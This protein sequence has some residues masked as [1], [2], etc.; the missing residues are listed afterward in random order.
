[1]DQVVKYFGST[2]DCKTFAQF[3]QDQEMDGDS[4]LYLGED[5]LIEYGLK[6]DL[7]IKVAHHVKKLAQS[8]D[9]L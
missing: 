3:C 7:A 6:A 9:I 1:M 2:S 5:F 4:L 8:R